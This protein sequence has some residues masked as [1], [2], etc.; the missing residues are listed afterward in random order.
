MSNRI[1]RFLAKPK[2]VKIGG[3]LVTVKPLAMGDFDLVIDLSSKDSAV[4]NK[5][6]REVLFRTLKS[7]FPEATREQMDSFSFEYLNDLLEAMMEVNNIKVSEGDRKKL[8]A[9]MGEQTSQSL[10]E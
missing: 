10:P 7:A 2:E 5:A 3:E 1:E 8:L 9:G 4:K 6:T